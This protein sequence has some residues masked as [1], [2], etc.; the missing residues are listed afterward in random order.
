MSQ[1][2]NVEINNI[3]SD[4]VFFKIHRKEK[5]EILAICDEYIMGQELFSDEIRIKVPI[6]FYR[7]NEI[8]KEEALHLLK[9]YR[10]INIFGSVITL[11][12][13]KEIISEEAVIWLQTKDGERIPHL[14]IFAM[15][16]L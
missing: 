1:S 13:E 4:R 16:S 7:G 5:T 2:N 14:L 8:Q 9:N 12:L 3:K 15:P 6:K 10:N 11:G